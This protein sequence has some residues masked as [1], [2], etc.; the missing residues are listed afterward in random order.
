M[1][2]NIVL[3]GFM[4][5]GKGSAARE[6][7]LQTGKFA[8][9]C[10]DLIQSYKNTKIKNIFKREGEGEFRKTEA[11][12]ADFLANSVDNAVISTGGGFFAVENLNKIGRVIYLK[13]SFEG[14]LNRLNSAPNSRKKFAKRPLFNKIEKA[15]K[16]YEQREASYAAKADFIV[17]TENKTSKKI[18]K[19]I[20][21]LL[22]EK[23]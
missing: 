9:D 6:L 22:K 13:S 23:N 7:A 3:I 17:D 15:K 10:D 12:L 21:N 8:L 5:V 19:E 1:K 16:L 4:G 2:N 14:I 11:K 18:A 20:I